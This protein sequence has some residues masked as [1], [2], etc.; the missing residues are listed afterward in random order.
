MINV[1]QSNGGTGAW[2]YGKS[3][4]AAPMMHYNTMPTHY[5]HMQSPEYYF[6]MNYANHE[7]MYPYASTDLRELGRTGYSL[8][9]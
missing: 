1:M 7:N 9:M 8:H 4:Y 6:K 3:M 2:D 5:P